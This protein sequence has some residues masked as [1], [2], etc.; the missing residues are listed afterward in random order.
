MKRSI[1][2]F[3]LSF[4]IKVLNIS[5]Q[6]DIVTEKA[7]TG[8]INNVM[9]RIVFPVNWNH[10]LVMFT[11]GY[12]NPSMPADPKRFHN[13]WMDRMVKPF[14]DRGFAVAR[15]AYSKRGWALPE[16]VDDTEALRKYFVNKYGKPDSTFVTGLSMG[17]GI[18]VA[19]I[20]NFSQYYQGALPMC[21]LAGRPYLQIKMALDMNAVVGALYPGTLASL[22]AVTDG[23]AQPFNLNLLE[24][25]VNKDSVLSGKVAMHFEIKTQDLAKVVGWNDGVLRDVSKQAG[26]NPIDNTNTMYTG[27]PDDWGLN[28]KVERIA[29]KPGT[30]WF[31]SRYD[32]TGNIN[33]PTVLVHTIYDP[34]IFPSLAIN[35]IDNLAQEKGK[36][37]N[38]VR[39]YTNKQGHC[40][41][42]A[43]ETGKAFDIMR[44]WAAT[45]KKPKSGILD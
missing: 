3:I 43:E 30:E 4:I 20:E 16:G 8:R 19:T 42:S 11:H 22:A 21:P 31:L 25:A 6:Q 24:E 39:Y 2:F 44:K 17:G 28:Q 37:Y 27:F 10:K 45:G 38:L 35:S 23:T 12:E 29:S 32:R 33:V 5:A 18:A 7:D 40:N 1:L 14:L 15:S 34:S 26:G 41:F 9:Y 13:S 36:Q